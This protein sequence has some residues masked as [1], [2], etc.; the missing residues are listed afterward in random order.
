[1][2]SI[3]TIDALAEANT[4]W[5][6]LRRVPFA[7]AIEAECAKVPEGWK[8]LKDSTHEERSWPEDSGHENGNYY[9]LCHNCGRQFTGHKRRVTCKVCAAPQP[10]P[11]AEVN[12]GRLAD[13]P[14]EAV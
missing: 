12:G 1:M 14:S 7:R 8:L 6:G 4:D 10:A 5:I 13:S 3:E 11:K 2:L 9:C